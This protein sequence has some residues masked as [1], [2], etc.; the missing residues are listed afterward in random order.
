[1]FNFFYKELIVAGVLGALVLFV[2]FWHYDTIANLDSTIDQLKLQKQELIKSIV[3][4]DSNVTSCELT[5]VTLKKEIVNVKRAKKVK[6]RIQERRIR[7]DREH[8]ETDCYNGCSS[9]I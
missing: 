2:K 6:E 5:V 1:M 9:T 8:E 4:L 7:N 3:S